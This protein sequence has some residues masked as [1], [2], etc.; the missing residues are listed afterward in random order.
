MDCYDGL[1]LGMTVAAA[2]LPRNRKKSEPFGRYLALYLCSLFASFVS[3]ATG[4]RIAKRV[5]LFSFASSA[6]TSHRNPTL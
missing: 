2:H 6:S 3:A 1:E 5:V 4:H